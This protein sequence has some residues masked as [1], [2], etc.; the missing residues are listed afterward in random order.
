MFDEHID[1]A[2]VSPNLLTE[3]CPVVGVEMGD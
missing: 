1:V 3:V 2:V